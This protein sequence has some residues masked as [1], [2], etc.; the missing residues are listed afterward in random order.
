M[1]LSR[2]AIPDADWKQ[3]HSIVSLTPSIRPNPMVWAWGWRSAGQSL[4]PMTGRYGLSRT[5]PVVRL[6]SSLSQL[7]AKKIHALGQPFSPQGGEYESMQQE[8]SFRSLGRR[9]VERS[10]CRIFH[11]RSVTFRE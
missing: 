3:R 8:S 5:R 2:F 7:L 9:L 11:N 10:F 6:F 4:K 1:S